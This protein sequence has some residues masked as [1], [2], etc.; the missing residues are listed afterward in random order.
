M[1]TFLCLYLARS[2]LKVSKSRN[3]FSTVCSRWVGLKIFFRLFAQA[4]QMLQFIF[5]SLLKLSRCPNLFFGVCSSWADAQIYFLEFAQ[6]EQIL[7]FIFWGLL[8]LS[9]CLNLFFEV[10]SRWADAQFYFLKFAQAAQMLKFIFWGLLKV[11]RCP[12]LFFEVCS[13]GMVGAVPACPPERPR[14]GVSIPKTHALCTGMNDGCALAGR[15]GRAHRH[16][17]YP[18]PSC[19]FAPFH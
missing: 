1:L 5:W 17:P 16:R 4:E 2:L 7:N 8:K 11:S 14:S 19:F 13:S 10:C 18:S 6:A 3:L 9:R 15:H 12:N